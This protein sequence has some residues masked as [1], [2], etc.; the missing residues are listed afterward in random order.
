MHSGSSNYSR[1]CNQGAAVVAD[2]I[3]EKWWYTIA[4]LDYTELE[5]WTGLT[6]NG[7]KCLLNSGFFSVGEKLIMHAHFRLLLS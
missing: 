7:V 6:Q 5:H 3:G 1:V 4:R 2:A